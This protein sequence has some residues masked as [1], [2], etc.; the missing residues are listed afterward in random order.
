MTTL[1][2]RVAAGMPRFGA[3]FAYGE[4]RTVDG[5]EIIP[6]AFVSYGFGAGEGVGAPTADA[7]SEQEFS[8]SGGGGGG[9]SIPVGAY[10]RRGGRLVFRPNPVALLCA[11][12]PAVLALGFGIAA[13]VRASR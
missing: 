6:V 8:G 9:M 10:L 3:T 5:E 7:P 11:S 13:I 1:I 2:E 4:N 12:V